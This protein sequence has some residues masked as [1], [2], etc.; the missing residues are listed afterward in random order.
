MATVTQK[1]VDFSNVKDGGGAFNKKRVPEGDYLAKIVNVADAVSK[2]DDVFQYLF[3]LELQKVSG[4]KYPYYCKLAENQLWKLRNLLIAAGLTVPKKKM[5][6]DVSRTIGKLVGVTME[7]DEYEGKQQSVIQAVF[8]AAELT[9][10]PV[11]DEETAEDIEDSE[12]DTEV[13]A[14][15]EEAVE[16]EVTEEPA[17]DDAEDDEEEPEAEADEF[18]GMDRTALKAYIVGKDSDFK[19]RKSQSDDDLRVIARELAVQG[20]EGGDDELEELDIEDL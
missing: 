3:T 15:E 18:A 11:D 14:P 12:D 7:D 9:D 5:K 1:V 20:D 2:K 8:P 6:L 17:A 16:D 10:S 4:A 19:A 13:D